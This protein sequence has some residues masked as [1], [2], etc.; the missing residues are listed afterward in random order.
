MKQLRMSLVFFLAA[1]VLCQTGAE[2]QNRPQGSAVDS[3]QF[4][5]F[6][7]SIVPGLIKGYEVPGAVVTAVQSGRVIFRRG[8]GFAEIDTKRPMDPV[9]TVV[10][11]A[12]VSKPITAVLIMQF[13]ASENIKLNDPVNPYLGHLQIDNPFS[14]PVRLRH[15][16]THTAGFDKVDVGR[17]GREDSPPVPLAD[18]LA[19][20]SPSVVRKPGEIFSYSNHGFALIGQIV[21]NV[22]RDSFA[23]CARKYLFDPLAMHHSSFEITQDLRSQLATGYRS[24]NGKF[25]PVAFDFVKTVPA[26]MMVTTADDFARFLLFLLGDTNQDGS[27]VLGLSFLKEMQRTQFKNSDA[28]PNGYG[29]GLFIQEGADGTD[30]VWQDG[31]MTGWAAEMDLYPA[32][33]FGVFMAFNSDDGSEVANELVE[34]I[35]SHFFRFKVKE[36]TGQAEFTRSDLRPFC[37]RWAYVNEPSASLEKIAG[38][39]DDGIEVDTHGADTLVFDGRMY[40]EIAHSVFM[41]EDSGRTYLAIKAVGE[42][43]ENYITTGIRAYRKIQWYERSSIHRTLLAISLIGWLSIGL[44]LFS[45]V[46]QTSN[47]SA[48]RTRRI[49]WIIAGVVFICFLIFTIGFVVIS[50]GPVRYGMPASM[51]LLRSIAIL[52]ILLS[53]LLP[54]VGARRWSSSFDS[55]FE[56]L[57]FAA[58]SFCCLLFACELLYWRVLI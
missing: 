26:S 29:F 28:L 30:W 45:L 38:L 25:V 21:A 3:A 50:G 12:S 51:K 34:H 17:F 56:R 11:I 36:P 43:S 4:A 58:I 47:N 55:R 22:H 8:Y 44:R 5:A 57:H 7:D 19:R 13:V 39:F 23:S 15:L 6:V 46:R 33:D 32:S 41:H 14:E 1:Q 31:D 53:L 9:N 37:G 16:L 40:V 27:D 54:A 52:G 24:H 2:A 10:R 48:E 35:K 49:R 20:N 18:Y 42:G